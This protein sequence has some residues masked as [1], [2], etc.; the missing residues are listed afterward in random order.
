[1]LFN[2][3]AFILVFLPFCL[4]VVWFAARFA[5][6]SAARYSLIALSLLFYCWWNP[7]HVVI[8][9][10]SILLNH[11]VAG[12]IYHLR[13]RERGD[14]ARLLLIAGIVANLTVLGYFKYIN[15]IAENVGVL[16]GENFQLHQIVLPLGI[17]FF[18]FEQITYLVDVYRRDAERHSLRDF[19]LFVTF[20]PHLIAGPILYHYEFIPQLKT[21]RA[22]AFRANDLAVGSTMFTLG[23][24]KKVF[25]ADSIAVYAT[26]AFRAADSGVALSF[27]EAWGGALAYTSQLYFDF[28]GYSDM[29]IGLALLFGLKLPINFNSPYKS[30]S[31]IDFWRRWHMTLSRFLRDYL[32]IPLGGNRHGSARRW[33]NLLITMLLGGLWHGAAWTFVI[34][35][36]LHGIYLCI[37]R[38]WQSL[39]SRL[40]GE[41][42]AG[43]LERGMAW[44][45]TFL[46]VVVAW[47]FFR[48][49]T[50]PGALS[51]LDGMAGGNGF[52]LPEQW[53]HRFGM[54][55][56]L[57]TASGLHFAPT[58]F[59]AGTWQLVITVGAL[60]IALFGPNTQEIVAWQHRA[61]DGTLFGRR[62]PL[63]ALLLGLAGAGALIRILTSGYSEFLYFQF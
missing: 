30:Q 21:E 46:A 23:L 40:L 29:A 14:A 49:E 10:G 22:F 13:M 9:L 25:I 17:S 31:I 12:G 11:L 7:L 37:N 61:G 59:F 16:I 48:A 38:A 27:I 42:P 18:T 44:G 28:S 60:L 41:L 24:L 56:P 5:G 62:G 36:G 1:M 45:I 47:V 26:P 34:W 54:L 15:F 33:I 51:M 43:R 8:L 53:Q 20:F 57:V 35:G 3:L 4:A 50:L 39:R 19:G 32:Y 52:V 58:P 2:S 55:G 63:V 6:S